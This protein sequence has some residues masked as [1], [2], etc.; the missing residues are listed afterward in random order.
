MP[1][2]P[3]AAPAAPERTAPPATRAAVRLTSLD[4]FR[5]FTMFWIA[6]GKGI[7]EGLRALGGNPVLAG[8]TY[9]LNHSAWQGLRYYDCIWPSFMLMVGVSVPFAIARRSQTQT[10]TQMLLHAIRRAVIL[11]LLGSLRETVSLGSPF[12]TELSSALQ[13][14]AVA[15]LVAFLLARKGPWVQGFVG[16]GLLAA[17]GLLLA[18]VP[19]LSAASTHYVLNANLVTD[20]D[21]RLLGRAHPEG[22]GTVIST[23]PTISTTIL[24]LMIGEVLRSA[25]PAQTKLRILAATG[26]GGLAL[27]YFLALFVP[28]VMKM[29][30][31]SYGILTA[32]W[33][34][35]ILASFYWV[36]DVRGW[37]KWSFPFAVI[38]MNALAAYLA[39]TLTQF[40]HIIRIFTKS[41][42]A[43]LGA[44]EPLTAALLLFGVEWAVLYWMY[45]RRIFLN[46]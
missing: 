15:Y 7:V 31:V 27:G 13:P 14:I 20:L 3:A 12:L 37:R 34:C 23:I 11:F 21:L 33:A 39:G 41:A 4:A 1:G 30:T 44:F 24:G 8:I 25:R 9:E 45:K 22:W 10:D 29:W 16:G 46:A 5:G 40:H 36:I 35:L 28:V 18:L 6:Q 38:G 43:S 26:V 17:Y 19:P 32:A 42:G 2:V